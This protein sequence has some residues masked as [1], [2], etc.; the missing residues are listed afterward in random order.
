MFSRLLT[1]SAPKERYLATAAE[2]GCSDPSDESLDQPIGISC[3]PYSTV[4]V[5]NRLDYSH[6]SRRQRSRLVKND[7]G[8]GARVL[9]SSRRLEEERNRLLLRCVPRVEDDEGDT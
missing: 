5:K 3:D 9:E 8:Y 7:V 1:E 2:T 4:F 6:L